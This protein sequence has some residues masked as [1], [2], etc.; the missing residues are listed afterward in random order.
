MTRGCCGPTTDSSDSD[1][2][3]G[4]R[5]DA[6]GCW[7]ARRENRGD[8]VVIALAL[9]VPAGTLAWPAGWTFL[10]L[11]I[12]FVIGIS[13]WLLRFDPVL[14]VE[15]TR[16]IGMPDQE[17]WDK[18]LLAFA[19]VAFFG[20]LALMGID[21]VRYRWSAMTPS[22]QLLGVLLLL[23]SF[24]VF[25]RVFRVNTYLSPGWAPGTGCSEQR[26]WSRSLPGGRCSKSGC[27][28]R[29]STDTRLT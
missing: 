28:E 20:W 21:V 23:C 6:G 18:A 4:E 2:A 8:R 13:A 19:G 15:R 1:G 14:L 26:S 22:L 16:G 24:Y 29:N 9:F 12:L 27:Y 11:F 5:G 25:F 10:A 17:R 7:T 3:T